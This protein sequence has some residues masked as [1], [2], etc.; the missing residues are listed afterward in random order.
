VLNLIDAY[1][2]NRTNH[3]ARNTF[4]KQF[5]IKDPQL[6]FSPVLK[7]IFYEYLSSYPLVADSIIVGADQIMKKLAC[8]DKAYASTFNY[9]ATVLQ[10]SSIK[11]NS[12]AYTTLIEKYLIN[13][14]CSFLAKKTADEFMASY[15]RMKQIAAI[16]TATNIILQD[17][18]GKTYSLYDQIRLYD[19]TLISFYD[20]TCEHCQDQMPE[21]DS[22]LNSIRTLTGL[23]LLHF[24]VCNTDMVLEKKWKQFIID[25][26]LN[27]GYVHVILADSTSVR[28]AYGAYS[29]P[30]F[31]LVDS[32]KKV[33]LKKASISSIKKY[34]MN[35][36]GS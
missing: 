19:F 31:F 1:T 6:Y 9:F 36:K 14:T 3:E 10:N 33:L 13:N 21:L 8:K 29:N 26:Q 28:N 27:D 5:D 15:T 12:K 30:I 20:P 17:T 16:D 22:T 34:L 25:N 32:S 7:E 35:P 4:L 11:D 23:K 2:P 18:A 24:A